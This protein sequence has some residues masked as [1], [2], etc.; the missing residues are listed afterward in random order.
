MIFKSDRIGRAP[1]PSASS[2]KP[3]DELDTTAMRH[4]SPQSCVTVD[5]RPCCR[6]PHVHATSNRTGRRLRRQSF[7]GS[8]IGL[9]PASQTAPAQPISTECWKSSL[10][11]RSVNTLQSATWLAS[12]A[13]VHVL[14]NG[15]GQVLNSVMSSSSHRITRP[16]RRK[17]K[18]RGRG[19]GDEISRIVCLRKYT[20]S[21]PP[22]RAHVYATHEFIPLCALPP[23][24]KHHGES[25][26]IYS[27]N[28]DV[29]RWVA[30]VRCPNER[31][32]I[33]LG[34]NTLVPALVAS[35]G[36]RRK[37]YGDG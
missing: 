25:S 37:G 22:P 13:F 24:A 36:Y 26:S 2:N 27:S 12:Q 29:F 6:A 5:V 3:R 21:H 30:S 17:N 9:V 31:R 7:R 23:C 32:R 8:Q 11:A 35:D 34:E 20:K 1:L 15:A 10:S 28:G 18:N 4:P 33:V 14:L 16:K 19:R